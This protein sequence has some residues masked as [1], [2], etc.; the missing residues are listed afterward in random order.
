MHSELLVDMEFEHFERLTFPEIYRCSS[1]FLYFKVGIDEI[2]I[3]SRGCSKGPVSFI[4][5]FFQIT[6]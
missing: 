3:E 1:K 2:G 5:P 4:I 6:F